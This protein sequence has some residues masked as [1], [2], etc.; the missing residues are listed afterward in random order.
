MSE[1]LRAPTSSQLPHQVSAIDNSVADIKG[2]C[3]EEEY[4]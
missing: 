1:S 3:S 2:R 4:L